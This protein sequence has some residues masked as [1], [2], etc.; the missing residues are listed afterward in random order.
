MRKRWGLCYF[1][2]SYCGLLIKH[3][4]KEGFID[5][6][7]SAL[8]LALRLS[9]LLWWNYFISK[10]KD[11]LIFHQVLGDEFFEENKLSVH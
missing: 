3:I 7:P 10:S 5:C 6:I 4:S 2:D 1:C 9:E 8:W 11:L